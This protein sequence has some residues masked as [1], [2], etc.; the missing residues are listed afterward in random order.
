M[1]QIKICGITTPEDALLATEAGADAIGLNFY[2]K[3]PRFVTPDRAAQI[4]EALREHHSAEQVRVFGVF[5][6]ASLDE[7]L[8]TIRDAELYGVEQGFGIQLHGDEPPELLRDLAGQGLGRTGELLQVAGHV[9]EVPVIR[10][11][12]WRGGDLAAEHA[13]LRRCEEL[14]APPQ[15]V[16]IDGYAAGAYG[17]T[18]HTFDWA[19]LAN[20][21][22]KLLGLPVIVAGGLNPQNVAEAIALSR[23]DAVDVTSG[24][25]ASPGRKDAAKVYAFG[26]AAKQAHKRRRNVQ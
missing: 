23:A 12:R 9:P 20:E 24:V 17:G 26:A 6:N 10:A 16:L 13:Y 15:A 8:W 18:G 4:V 3:S 2:K 1:F 7:I 14:G 21:R 25:E 22:D 5:V 19:L 11:F